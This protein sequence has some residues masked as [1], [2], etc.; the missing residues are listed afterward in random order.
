[1]KSLTDVLKII[2][3]VLNTIFLAVILFSISRHGVHPQAF[4]DWAGIILVFALPLVT[5][6]TIALTFYKKVQILTSVL[7]IITIII[8]AYFLVILIYAMA[9]ERAYLEGLA[10]LMVYLMC[11]GLPVVNVLAVVLT[12]RKGKAT[13]DEI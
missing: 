13:S 10:V 9:V 11:S 2:A 7:K 1:M 3:I 6:V 8:N 12:F 5:L 4:H